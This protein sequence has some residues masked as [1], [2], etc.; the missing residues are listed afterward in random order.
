MTKAELINK[1]ALKTGIEKITSLAVIEAFMNE[2]KETISE[3]ESIFLRG[4]G[5]FKPKKRAKKK[6]RNDM[7]GKNTTIIIPAHYIPAFKPAKIFKE[8]VK[9]KLT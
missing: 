7:R 3:N 4:F 8:N 2:I 9:K 5:T 6:A 1:I